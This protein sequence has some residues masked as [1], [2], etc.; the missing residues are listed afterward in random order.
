MVSEVAF[1]L[2]STLL[3]TLWVFSKENHLL[4]RL[5]LT[6]MGLGF[7][8]FLLKLVLWGENH[9]WSVFE[10]LANTTVGI[11]YFLLVKFRKWQVVRFSPVVSLVALFFSVLGFVGGKFGGGSYSVLL[12]VGISVFTF[13]LLMLS[14]IFS[15]FR[16]VAQNRLKRKEL[17]LPLGIPV[18][19]WIKL[20][21]G[22]FFFGFIFLTLD[23]ILNFLWLE[24][25]LKTAA[26]DSRIVATILLWVYYWILF[27]ADRW[28]INPIRERFYL[29]NILG[30][31][32]L[33]L[34]LMVT[35]HKF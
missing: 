21:R 16:V 34:S 13:T 18:N 24:V 19:L 30:S 10:L 29:F 25:K 6:L 28:G 17:T 15:L 1:Y 31:L 4:R 23:L 9:R 3:L 12:H 2:L 11:F 27:H 32:M 14:A 22:F 35:R 8:S 26:W 33:I 7:I 20:E 5:G